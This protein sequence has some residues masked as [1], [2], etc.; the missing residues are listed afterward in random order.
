MIRGICHKFLWYASSGSGGFQQE[1][2][3][4]EETAS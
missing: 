3:T 4:T 2:Q 1:R